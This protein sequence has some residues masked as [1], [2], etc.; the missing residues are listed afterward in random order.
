MLRDHFQ[1]FN[2]RESD[3]ELFGECRPEGYAIDYVI[4][5]P[6]FGAG[7]HSNYRR[8]RKLM[9]CFSE[10]GKSREIIIEGKNF[11]FKK[12]IKTLNRFLEVHP[13]RH[14]NETS[15]IEHSQ[16]KIN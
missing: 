4:T 16:Y 7:L 15:G 9:K 5:A 1:S 14:L 12:L 10:I 11:K 3:I 13:Q 2:Y 8:S 6:L